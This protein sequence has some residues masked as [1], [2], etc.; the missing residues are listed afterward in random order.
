MKKG[1][2]LRIKKRDIFKDITEDISKEEERRLLFRRN[3]HIRNADKQ[4]ELIYLKSL[5]TPTEI[6]ILHFIESGFTQTEI[7]KLLF[8]SKASVKDHVINI[9]LKTGKKNVITVAQRAREIGLIH[10]YSS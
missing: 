4:F 10:I 2:L 7:S 9:L 8:V 3:A 1:Q 6:S 5:L